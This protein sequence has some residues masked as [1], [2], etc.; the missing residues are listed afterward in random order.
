MTAS[1][2]AW[3]SEPYVWLMIAI[4]FSAVIMGFFML[5]LAINS[6]D[7]VVVDD[8]YKQGLA[9]NERLEREQMAQQ[10]G[11]RAEVD[12]KPTQQVIFVSLEAQAKDYNL[13]AQLELRFLH[14]TQAGHDRTV[15]LKRIA[16]TLYQADL[17]QLIAGNWYLQLTTDDWR[18][19]KSVTL[20]RQ[21]PVEILPELS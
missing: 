4:P 20:P 3:Y 13:P 10:L 8:Y 18:M 11:L 6:D 5:R 9:I 21:T 12:F 2:K 1:K 16:D 17:P 14:R 19:L 7:G 15:I